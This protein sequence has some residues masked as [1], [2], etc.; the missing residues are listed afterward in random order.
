[1]F[2]LA[3]TISDSIPMAM[4]LDRSDYVLNLVL[5]IHIRHI[6]RVKVSPIDIPWLCYHQQC[7][8]IHSY[9]NQNK[10]S[11]STHTVLLFCLMPLSVSHRAFPS[12]RRTWQV[13]L[14]DVVILY[15]WKEYPELF[16]AAL[17]LSYIEWDVL[18]TFR[19]L[20]NKGSLFFST[21]YINISV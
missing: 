5:I 20:Q 2:P 8:P 6:G 15:T 10:L 11:F 3:L 4:Y 19:S 7:P 14:V 13:G 17:L 1:M 18:L 21:V 12:I 16:N 9:T